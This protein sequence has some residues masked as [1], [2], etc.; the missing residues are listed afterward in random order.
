MRHFFF[1]I[2]FYYAITVV[3]IFPPLPTSTQCPLL[4]Q[5]I[6]PPLFTSMGHVYK[7][8]GYF[9]SYTVLYIP[10]AIL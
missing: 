8:F 1:L 5:A 3:L 10:M 7:L 2:Q 6:P 9:V 4:P